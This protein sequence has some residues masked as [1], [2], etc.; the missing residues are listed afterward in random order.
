MAGEQQTGNAQPS[1]AMA[2]RMGVAVVALA[3]VG[4]GSWA[5]WSRANK[6]T[7]TAY[8]NDAAGLKAGASVNLDGVVVGAVKVVTIS[9]APEHKAAPVQVTMSLDRSFLYELHSDSTAT[10]LSL[11]PLGDSEID[12]DSL[13]ATGEPMADGAVLRSVETPGML[14]EK[15]FQTTIDNAGKTVRRLDTV[16]DQMESGQ[17]SLGRF[18][19]DRDMENRTA[20]A[21]RNLRMLS[22]KLNSTHNSAGK[23]LHD[24]SLTQ[25]VSKLATDAQ[26]LNAAVAKLENG[27][28]QANI[29]TAEAQASALRK[30]I[31]AGDGSIGL[32]V[33][34]PEF[35]KTLADTTAHGSALASDI[36]AGKGTLGKLSS[37]AVQTNLTQLTTQCRELATAIGKNPKQVLSFQ[38]R[39]F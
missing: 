26:G 25:N 23:L 17:G 37:G 4:L 9:S 7:A 33:S 31:D 11:G 38:I 22:A 20:E 18:M 35:R 19:S 29:A 21:A 2:L 27:P 13:N 16:V 10:I 24:P 28:L 3:A 32:L 15:A 1:P 8:F 14:D 34:N 12:I 30:G 5:V 6:L 39:L 36:A